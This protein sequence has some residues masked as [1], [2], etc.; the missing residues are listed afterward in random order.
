M[1]PA[2]SMR[3]PTKNRGCV[4][5]SP[6]F[7]IVKTLAKRAYSRRTRNMLKT[8]NVIKLKSNYKEFLIKKQSKKES[9][10]QN[11]ESR[12]NTKRNPE[13]RIQI[14]NKKKTTKST[15]TTKKKCLDYC[16]CLF[17]FFVLFVVKIWGIS[18]KNI[19]DSG[20]WILDSRRAI[21]PFRKK[22]HMLLWSKEKKC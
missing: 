15:T 22:Q 4:C 17:V 19:L 2:M 20:F 18:G 1:M 3:V 11:S 13:F 8:S 21:L 12:M 6:V 7:E 5:S 14:Q 16:E 10:I 9:R